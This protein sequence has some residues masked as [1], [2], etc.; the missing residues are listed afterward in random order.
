MGPAVAIGVGAAVAGGDAITPG[1]GTLSIAFYGAAM[2]GV[3]LAVGGLARASWAGPA[4]AAVA[5]GTFLLD[6]LAEPL[7]LP[8]WLHQLALS[9]HLGQPLAGSWSGIGLAACLL[10]AAAG[11]LLGTAGLRRRDLAR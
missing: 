1:V 2:A 6:F 8:D 10:I 9:T 3:G 7:R 4:V 11:L 5:I